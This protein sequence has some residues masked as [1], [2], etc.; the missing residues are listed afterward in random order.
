MANPEY[1]APQNYQQKCLCVLLLDVSGS[2]R[3]PVS[4]ESS[5]RRIDKLNE[6]IASFYDDVVNAKNGVSKQTKG[7]LEV[8][9]V[10]FDQEPK[11]IY[12]PKLLS[13]TERLPVLKE[14][15]STTETALALDFV[16]NDVIA[17]RKRY[18]SETGLK[19]YRPWIVL[20]TDGNPTSSAEAIEHIS[21]QIARKV[22]EKKF[23]II[24]IGVGDKV[25][26]TSLKKITANRALPLKDMRFAQFFSW[27]SNS[28]SNI[29]E[30]TEDDTIDLT[31]GMEFWTHYKP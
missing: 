21:A 22:N 25:S 11:L 4:E 30:S 20:I 15:G 29:A 13:K 5:I 17:E 14:R 12:G 28:I 1:K 24:G 19:Y 26:M 31:E 18:Y 3:K 23:T 8:A 2:M 16:I 10:A 27:L 6:A 7:M 9:I